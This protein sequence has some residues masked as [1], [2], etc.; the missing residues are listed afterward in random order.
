MPNKKALLIASP[1]GGLKGPLGDASMVMELLRTI[2]FD[3]AQ[4]CGASATRDGILQAWR[5]LIDNIH[6]EDCVVVYYSGHGGMVESPRETPKDTSNLGV[7]PWRYQFIVPMDFKY[8]AKEDFRGILDIELSYLVR[9]MT[10]KTKNATV[11]FD[12]CY[13]G[14]MVRDPEFGT[15]AVAKSLSEVQYNDISKYVNSLRDLDQFRM[16]AEAEGNLLAIRIAAAAANQ[17]AWEYRNTKGEWHGA[18]T[19]ALVLAISESRSSDISWRMTMLRVKELVNIRFSYQHPR[20]EGPV[21]RHHFSLQESV[22][23][24]FHIRNEANGAVIQAGRVS[25]VNQGNIYSVMRFGAKEVVA[26]E[27][28]AEA[29]VTSVTAFKAMT[30]LSFNQSQATQLPDDGAMAFI[31]Y[32]TLSKWPVAIP[33][34]LPWLDDLVESSRFIR[35][36]EPDEDGFTLAEFYHEANVIILR[37]N[38]GLGVTATPS[39]PSQEEMAQLMKSA[40]Q[41]ARAQHLLSLEHDAA[42]E[43]LHH[44]VQVTV[45]LV[46]YQSALGR[47]LGQ[48]GSDYLTEGDRISISLANDG[49]ETVYVSVFDINAVGKISL[50]SRSSDIELPQGR[51][52]VLGRS[53]YGF[54]VPG[55]KVSWPQGI[56]RAQ[57]LRETLLLFVSSEPA[58]LRHLADPASQAP[59]ERT[60]LSKLEQLTWSISTGCSRKAEV[61]DDDDLRY[62]TIHIPFLLRS[63]AV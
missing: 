36:R 10:A 22:S 50:I 61:V 2:G 55:L 7:T 1:F 42:D 30:R 6:H 29:H 8:T 3:I 54:T 31:R 15:W 32:E 39:N 49:Y 44:R 16:E 37:S 19:E 43:I 18:M 12:C 21:N 23:G 48:D 53:P 45:Q 62:S 25:G 27:Q 59:S 24:A 63:N 13:A 60:G 38:H 17:T 40:E 33:P 11:I 52:E 46:G 4:C 51:C 57:P 34:G 47:V 56:S 35:R 28:L 20:A 14:R 58:G 26:T 5:Q 9:E 41:L